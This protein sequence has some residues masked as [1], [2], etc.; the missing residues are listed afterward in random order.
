MG[1]WSFE[2]ADKAEVEE[3]PPIRALREAFEG[4]GWEF[5]CFEFATSKGYKRVEATLFDPSAP[6]DGV[7]EIYA[8]VPKGHEGSARAWADALEDKVEKVFPRKSAEL[9]RNADALREFMG[10]FRVP[11]M[12]ARRAMGVEPEDPTPGWMPAVCV[13]AFTF[14]DLRELAGLED[15]P[16][17]WAA[18]VSKIAA[19]NAVE[20]MRMA[21][22]APEGLQD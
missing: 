1:S 11:M 2:E 17:A 20:A 19:D 16:D 14:D 10:R 7:C 6:E 5:G 12:E 4:H 15:D 21:G 22:L 9:P 3:T 18:R 8:S 13:P